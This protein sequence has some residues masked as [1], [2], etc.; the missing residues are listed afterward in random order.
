MNGQITLINK[1]LDMMVCTTI[2]VLGKS[3]S[4][5]EMIVTNLGRINWYYKT[6]K[7]EKWEFMVFLICDTCPNF[8][9]FFR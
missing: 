8:T 2:L 7:K 3:E 4:D 6:G 9:Y 1:N 5:F